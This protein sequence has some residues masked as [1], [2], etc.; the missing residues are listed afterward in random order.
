MSSQRLRPII[1]LVVIAVT[2]GLAWFLSTGT[3]TIVTVEWSTA[4]ELNTAGFNLYRGE[5]PDGPFQK[6]NSELI[7]ASTDPLV[8]GSYAYT[9][10]T[11]I[12]GRTY[13]YRLEDVETSGRTSLQ[14]TVEVTADGGM[15]LPLM[16]AA[17][18]IVIIAASLWLRK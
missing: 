16:L 3:S 8:G 13:F 5:S 7:P 15:P 2:I 4:S 10:T 17:A 12:A 18:V 9:D 14:G 11:V 6:I 1:L